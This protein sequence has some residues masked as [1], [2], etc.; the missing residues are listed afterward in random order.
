[1]Y[2]VCTLRTAGT[3]NAAPI[4]MQRTPSYWMLAAGIV[5]TPSSYCG[6]CKNGGWS[7]L[8]LLGQLVCVCTAPQ[9]PNT[10]QLALGRKKC[11]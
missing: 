11:K 3:E 8:Q 7:T 4:M 9:Q 6:G 2:N 10:F 5:Q 1:M